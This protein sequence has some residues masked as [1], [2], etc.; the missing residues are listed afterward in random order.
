ME[1]K[2]EEILYDGEQ[3]PEISTAAIIYGD[4]I[5]WITIIATLIVLIGSVL[6][7]ITKGNYIDPGYM[8]TAI[9]DGKTVDQIW[10]GAVGG[11]P[12][13]HWYLGEISTGDGLT[14]FGIALGVF[15]VVPGI[16]G[17]GIFL[18]K[19]N[20]KLFAS[21]AMIAAGIILIAMI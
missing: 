18:F 17:A 4:S 13:G 14:M 11:T 5:Y 7:F 12:N 1:N 15:S 20:E 10:E 8:L 6:S 21:L 9:W 19:E 3:R 16:I 2:D